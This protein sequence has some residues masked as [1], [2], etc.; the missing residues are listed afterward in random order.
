MIIPCWKLHSH[1]LGRFDSSKATWEKEEENG[2]ENLGIV[3]DK[4]NL[5]PAYSNEICSFLVQVDVDYL[6]VEYSSLI[7]NDASYI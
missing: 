5:K 7:K 3:G 4:F 1:F 2:L 6:Y